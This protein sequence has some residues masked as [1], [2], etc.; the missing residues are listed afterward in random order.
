MTVNCSLEVE[1]LETNNVDYEVI[2]AT[3]GQEVTESEVAREGNRTVNTARIALNRQIENYYIECRAALLHSNYTWKVAQT[4]RYDQVQTYQ[5]FKLL[6]NSNT[7]EN[8]SSKPVVFLSII[9]SLV[10]PQ[11]RLSL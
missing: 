11:L 2:I 6:Y 9:I 4:F 7:P 5:H 10:F 8:F 3:N 1:D